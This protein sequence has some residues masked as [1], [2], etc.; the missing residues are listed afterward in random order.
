MKVLFVIGNMASG[1]AQKSLI[2]LLQAIDYSKHEIS[3][4]LMNHDGLYMDKIPSEVKLLPQ[5]QIW[6]PI[7]EA[8]KY[9]IKKGNFGAIANRVL[10]SYLRNSDKG[11]QNANRRAWK[12]LSRSVKN[13][14]D[15]YDVAI[16]YGDGYPLYFVVDKCNAEKKVAWNHIDYKMYGD[17]PEFDLENFEK[18]KNIVTMSET[19]ADVLREVFPSQINKV[20]VIENIISQ[21]VILSLAQESVDKFAGKEGE[22]KILTVGRLAN[23]KGYDLAIPACKILKE[24]GI[25]F[26]WYVIGVGDLRQQLETM[27]E[28]NGLTDTMFFLGERV[29]PYAYMAHCD[30]YVHCARVE[31]KPIVIDEVKMVGKPIVTTNFPTL[32]NQIQ[33]QYNG[34]VTEL[35]SR[36]IANGILEMINNDD[37]RKQCV[38]NLVNN[39]HSNEEAV[40]SQ[41]YRLIGG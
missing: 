25:K 39:R 28:E 1:G 24:S 33:N 37:L 5:D 23:Q 29:N 6:K 22:I 16:A 10:F 8:V 27:C 18:C 19:C 13:I 31:G 9:A 2:S 17:N 41:F 11:T 35:D 12:L 38:S 15:Q 32:G 21:R 14:S 26:K 36:A 30:I 40:L 20:Q 34:I 3:L 7:K 4:Y